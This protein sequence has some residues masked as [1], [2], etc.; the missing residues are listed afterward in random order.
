[1]TDSG[2][3]TGTPQLQPL[4]SGARPPAPLPLWGFLALPF[5]PHLCTADTFNGL[6]ELWAL[7]RAGRADGI[8]NVSNNTQFCMMAFQCQCF[9]K[10][11]GLK[12]EHYF[13]AFIS[14]RAFMFPNSLM[15][16][17]GASWYILLPVIIPWKFVLK[18]IPGINCQ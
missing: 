18:P 3:S 9:I 11:T 17:K 4:P 2:G 7:N 5:H 8:Y 16:K 10:L 1:M 12:E 14:N 6:R 13:S 15:E